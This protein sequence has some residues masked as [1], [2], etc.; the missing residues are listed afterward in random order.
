MVYSVSNLEQITCIHM[1]RDTFVVLDTFYVDFC[2]HLGNRK[3]W[4]TNEYM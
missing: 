3:Y 2:L 1:Y 4:D